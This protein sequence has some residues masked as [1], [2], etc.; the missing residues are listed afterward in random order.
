MARAAGPSAGTLVASLV[1]VPSSQLGV[2]NLR[3]K[4]SVGS[5]CETM[6]LS[7]AT[8]ATRERQLLLAHR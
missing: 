4:V 8:V 7:T 6:T 1:S 2:E 3:P 5:K